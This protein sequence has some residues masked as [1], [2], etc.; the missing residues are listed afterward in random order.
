MRNI[1]YFCFTISQLFLL[2]PT[3]LAKLPSE[4][5]P[6]MKS[7]LKEDNWGLALWSQNQNK[8][9]ISHNLNKSFIPA[10]TTKI[11]TAGFAL[12]NLGA[13]YIFHTNLLTDGKVVNN[14]LIGNLYLEGTGDP[15]LE[16]NELLNLVL[17]LKSKGIN[18][19]TGNFYYDDTSMA[20]TKF[21]SPHGEI[22]KPDNPSISALSTEFNRFKIWNTKKIIPNLDHIHIFPS[23]GPFNINTSF[24]FTNSKNS[25]VWSFSKNKKY[26]LVEELPIRRPSLFTA[27]FFKLFCSYLNI[28]IKNPTP[29]KIPYN[30]TLLYGQSS[31]PLHSLVRSMLLYSNNL[32]AETIAQKSSNVLT[33]TINS[34][35]ATAKIVQNW[36]KNKYNISGI[37]LENC[38]GLTSDNKISPN[39]FIKI[40]KLFYKKNYEGNHFLSL[41]PIISNIGWIKKRLNDPASSFRVIAK[42]GSI[43]YVN[44]ISGSIFSNSGDTL[45][46]SILI[47]DTEKRAFIDKNPESKEAFLLKQNARAWYNQ[48]QKLQDKLIKSWILKY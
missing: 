44:T 40:L 30:A 37:K 36:F 22:D 39:A 34:Q 6:I 3:V 12:E 9:I 20:Y 18:K 5:S 2:F 38:S 48:T 21:I 14:E 10:S 23:K 42:T 8:L 19:I 24:K 4:I 16:A 27:H 35:Q 41:F 31:K 26:K 46:F 32:L 28:E 17:S 11:L 43:D 13:N 47:N 29:K 15:F 33:N 7:S 1:I 25:E 45:F